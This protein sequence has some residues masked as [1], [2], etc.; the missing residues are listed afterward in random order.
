[1]TLRLILMRHAKSD[2]SGDL[3]DHDRSLNARGRASAE[4]LG[5]W[6]REKRITPGEILCS[7]ARRTVETLE[8]LNLNGGHTNLSDV[9]YL[10]EAETLL[11]A[12]RKG[13]SET[14]LL[15]A[16]NPGIGELANHIL[17]RPVKHPRFNAYPTGATLIATFD[18]GTWEEVRPGSGPVEH[19]TVPR[20]LV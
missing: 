13:V 4:A 14:Q 20:E 15:L 8:R 10:A 3:T 12:I 5:N 1:M 18:S 7:S 19:F 11:H 16:H 9:L 6:L 2:W 17:D